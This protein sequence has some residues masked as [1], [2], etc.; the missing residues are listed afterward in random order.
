MG[1]GFAPTWLRQVSLPPASHD[2]FNNWP[3]WC[4]PVVQLTISTDQRLKIGRAWE[5]LLARERLLHGVSANFF[6][7]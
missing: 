2:N 4:F 6:V 1:M 7:A 5:I 3:A